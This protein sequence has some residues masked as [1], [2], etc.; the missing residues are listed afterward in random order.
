MHKFPPETY[1]YILT[2]LA[3]VFGAIVHSTSQLKIARQ[4][5]TEYTMID[6][7]IN[8]MIS[9]FAGGTF[10][11]LAVILGLDE[12]TIILFSAIGS[13]LG[14]TGLNKLATGGLEFVLGKIKS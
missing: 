4:K 12:N 2:M 14:L 11:L 8:F 3:I 1:K 7:S 5:S 10:G 13:F 6:F 9:L